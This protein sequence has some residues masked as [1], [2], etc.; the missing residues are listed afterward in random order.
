MTRTLRNLKAAS[1]EFSAAVRWYEEQ[2]PG[3]GGE[4]FDAV[5]DATSLIQVQPEIGTPSR[6]GRTRRVLVQGFPYQVVYRVSAD[7]IVIVAIA[8]LKRRPGYWR[9]RK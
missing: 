3:L 8:H 2:R 4:F 1:K 6:D 7:E 5:V 9:K